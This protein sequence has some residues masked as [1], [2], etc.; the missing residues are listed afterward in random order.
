MSQLCRLS[1]ISLFPTALPFLHPLKYGSWVS[2]SKTRLMISFL[3]MCY[4]C[5][6]EYHGK[7]RGRDSHLQTRGELSI[8]HALGQPG[9]ATWDQGSA[10]EAGLQRKGWGHTADVE[11]LS[12]AHCLLQGRDF[13]CVKDPWPRSFR[14]RHLEELTGLREL[15]REGVFLDYVIFSLCGT[16]IRGTWGQVKP[17]VSFQDPGTTSKPI[18][19]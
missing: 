14:D 9:G 4:Y 15:S 5:R 17:L 16:C 13:S 1:Y 12:W 19:Y 8:T 7:W 3:N 18:N 11:A 6:T 10:Q 2:Y